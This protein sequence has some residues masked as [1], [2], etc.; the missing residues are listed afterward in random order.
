[1]AKQ[2]LFRRIF[3][4][5][6]RGVSKARHSL[7]NGLRVLVG[8]SPILNDEVL[9]D[10][11][12]QLLLADFGVTATTRIIDDIRQANREGRIRRTEQVL[13]WL[14]T[15]L[16]GYWPQAD[17]QVHMSEDGPTVIM[18]AGVNGVGKTTSIAKLAKSFK[19]GGLKV[20][21]AASDTFRA[22]AVEQLAIWADRLGV[23]IIKHKTGSD[24]GAVAY[25]A[26]EAAKARGVE[27]LIVDTAGRLHTQ[28]NL[29]REL[30]KIRR[31]IERQ[32]PGAPHEVLLVLDATT[33]QNAI[34]QA[35]EFRNAIDVSGIIL[36]KMDG[37][38]KGGIVVAIRDTVDIPVKFIG[39]GETLDDLQ[40]FD[41]D[42]FV[43]ALLGADGEP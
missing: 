37:T 8:K 7:Q 9:D 35:R 4:T 13:D 2:G 38:A 21:L 31:V 12:E 25:D 14:K 17:R 10:I 20:L 32:I 41:P 28:D 19:D 16:K 18:V 36:A 15:E 6:A 40:P 43:E 26:C 5:V 27:V 22:A 24:P 39:V 33:G 34:N 23:E 42:S 1:V 11:E 30:S 3:S 29:M